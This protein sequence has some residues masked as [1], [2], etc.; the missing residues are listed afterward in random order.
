MSLVRGT[1]A[2]IRKLFSSWMA[3]GIVIGGLG[4]VLVSV[5]PLL[6]LDGTEV[7]IEAGV[8]LTDPENVQILLGSATAAN[9]F[10]VLLGV[11]MMTTEFRHGTI[12]SMLLGEPRRVLAMVAK[13]C[14][15][16]VAGLLSALLITAV[17][18]AIVVPV[19]AIKGIDAT[20]S[21]G[22]TWRI[23]VGG[24]GALTLWCPI[25]VALGAFIRN[26]I[27][28]I[29]IAIGWFLVAENVLVVLFP[30]LGRFLLTGA[31]AAIGSTGDTQ[32]LSW[33]GGALV[34]L[35][36]VGVLGVAAAFT[37]RRDIK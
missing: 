24:I 5:I 32:L 3:P 29:L 12:T 17:V 21:D 10:I 18:F 16:V 30:D 7:G 22:Q 2:E 1:R 19:L 25:G 27:A 26:Q 33:W 28:A 34:M 36:Y 35:A 4:F 9:L 15:G 6:A 13:L 8:D 31:S 20:L 11:V 37:L 23:V 14:G